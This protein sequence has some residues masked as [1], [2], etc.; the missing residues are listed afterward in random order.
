MGLGLL[1]ALG[2][3][4]LNKKNKAIEM[5]NLHN[6][7]EIRTIDLSSFDSRIKDCTFKIACDVSNPLCG[8]NGA[9]LIFGKQKGLKNKDLENIDNK[10]KT[11]AKLCQKV[12]NKDLENIASTGA[13]GGVGFA[14]ATFLNAELV[15]GAELILDTIKFDDHLSNADIV[16]IGEGKMDKQSLYGKIPITVAKRAKKHGVSKV[17]AIIGSYDLK[18]KDIDNSAIDAIFSTINYY[19]D[20]ETIL[21]NA[22]KNIEQTASNIAKL[23]I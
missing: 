20:L 17:I 4:F 21:S 16:I 19:T 6:I 2:A 7:D 3:N 15:L 8:K 22:S 9:T 23:L 1:Q 14:L 12:L 10:I 11:F 13:A 5:C 18:E